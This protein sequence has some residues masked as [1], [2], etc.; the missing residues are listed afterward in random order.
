[1]GLAF[2]DTFST[3]ATTQVFNSHFL[4][5][6]PC[7]SNFVGRYLTILITSLH[8][9]ITCVHSASVS[10]RK[11]GDAYCTVPHHG[12]PGPARCIGSLA[13]LCLPIFEGGHSRKEWLA[14]LFLPL[15]SRTYRQAVICQGEHR[16]RHVIGANVSVCVRTARS[17]FHTMNFI[18][19]IVE[20]VWK[21]DEGREDG[22][23]CAR[24][25]AR[26]DGV[27]VTVLVTVGR[28]GDRG[29]ERSAHVKGVRISAHNVSEHEMSC[30][31]RGVHK[32]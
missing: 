22:R 27:D 32:L 17:I 3:F 11:K 10:V 14:T 23:T 20:G 6:K 19:L 7:R 28:G 12:Q 24:T 15:L 31:P 5:C 4:T 1:M 16:V 25:H 29:P 8:A 18:M 30:S 9:H 26:A 21:R 2:R 13:I